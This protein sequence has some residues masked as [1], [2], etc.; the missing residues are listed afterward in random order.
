MTVWQAEWALKDVHT[1][2]PGPC[3]YVTLHGKSGYQLYDMEIIVN[4]PGGP[5]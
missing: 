1:L 4:Y 3:E 2:N 5:I